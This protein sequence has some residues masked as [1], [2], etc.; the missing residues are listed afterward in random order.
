[1]DATV[2]EDLIQFVAAELGVSPSRL[3]RNTR[4]F[5]DLGVDG[6]DGPEFM[7]AFA[8][9]FG[10]DLSGFDPSLHFG[11]EAG[12]NPFLWA[13]WSITGTGPRVVP[14]ELGDLQASV[15]MHRWITPQ[16]AA[17]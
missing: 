14:I 1:M 11:P 4:L 7:R 13:W 16:H 15:E 5:H 10:V 8:Q 9:R 3:A 12:P 6:A 17:V 2:R